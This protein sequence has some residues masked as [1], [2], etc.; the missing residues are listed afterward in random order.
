MNLLPFLIDVQVEGDI[1]VSQILHFH[2]GGDNP[3][4]EGVEHQNFPARVV[5]G[6]KDFGE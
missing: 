3:S 5:G 1:V 2:L 4:V 6:A